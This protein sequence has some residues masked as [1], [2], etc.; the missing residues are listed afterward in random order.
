MLTTLLVIAFGNSID[1]LD[2]SISK[3]DDDFDGL[4]L[5]LVGIAGIVGCVWAIVHIN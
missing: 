4:F 3:R 1:V 2:R 5:K